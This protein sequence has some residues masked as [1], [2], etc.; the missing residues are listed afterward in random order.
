[1]QHRH[2]EPARGF[3]Y[4]G[5][6]RYF[7]TF[8]TCY[9]APLFTSAAPVGLVLAQ[10]SRASSEGRMALLAYCFMPDHLHLLVR[11]ESEGSNCRDFIKRAKQYSGFRYSKAYGRKLWQRYGHDHVLRDD[12][13]TADVVRYILLNPVRAGLC[14][15]AADYPF[16]N[17][18]VSGA[19]RLQADPMALD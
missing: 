17:A 16:A 14:K 2:P 7:L 5:L 1:M 4:L 19:V 15:R 18:T 6:H 10:I 3:S 11:G 13:K 9:R 12:E 8:C